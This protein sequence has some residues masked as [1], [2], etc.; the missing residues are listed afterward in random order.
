MPFFEPLPSVEETDVGREHCLPPWDSPPISES[1]TVIATGCMVG[2]STNVIVTVPTIR[3]FHAGCL[4]D[5]ETVLRQGTL[6]ADEW[7]DLR[8]SALQLGWSGGGQ[9]PERLLRFGVRYADG[10]KAT[11]VRPQRRRGLA[12]DD[13]PASPLLTWRPGGSRGHR[14]VGGQFG[15]NHFALWLWP[16]PPAEAFEFAVEWPSAGIELT[17]VEFDGAAIEFAARSSTSYWPDS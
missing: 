11:T 6:S 3:A 15:L 5:V 14:S 9:L 8:M 17:I 16:L 4:L 7:W 2:R 12:G 13:P 10:R 1:G